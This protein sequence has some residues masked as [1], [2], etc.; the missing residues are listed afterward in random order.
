M[1]VAARAGFRFAL[2]N[3]IKRGRSEKGTSSK[4]IQAAAAVKR[5][6]GRAASSVTN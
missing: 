2:K 6:L 5:Y 3:R 4:E 1:C